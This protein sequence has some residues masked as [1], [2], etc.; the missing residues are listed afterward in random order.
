MEIVVSILLLLIGFYV[1]IK[2]SDIFVD[3][4]SSIATNFKMSKMMIALTVA[5]FGTCAPELAI[6]FQSIRGGSGDIALANVL[7]SKVVNNLEHF[8]SISQCIIA[9]R[10]DSCLDDVYDKVYTRDL[11]YK[12]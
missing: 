2:C 3:A 6:S 5:A 4:V 7:G 11:F 8:K 10:Y 1:L 9:N 12:D